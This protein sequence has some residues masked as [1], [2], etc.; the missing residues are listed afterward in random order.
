MI[1]RDIYIYPDLAEFPTEIT[2]ELRFQTRCLCNFLERN[3][4]KGLKFP[5]KGFKRICVIGSMAPKEGCFVNS[6]HV[7]SVEVLID[8]DQF[9]R[10]TEGQLQELFIGLLLGGLCK[11]SA[12]HPLPV[13]ALQAGIR[14]FRREGYRN[15]WVHKRRSFKSHGLEAVLD[16]QLT[17][18]RFGL[19]LTVRKGTRV[20]YQEWILETPPDEVIFGHR[21]KDVDV[22]E[23]TMVVTSKGR[24][25]LLV[26]PLRELEPAG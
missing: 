4:L 17:I 3:V 18:K 23:E 20:L 14:V 8:I 6:C 24:K 21:F 1:L 26:L 7:L 12:A 2:S 13:E 10:A 11:C 15:E 25:P 16:C 9:R 22:A 19:R 5:A